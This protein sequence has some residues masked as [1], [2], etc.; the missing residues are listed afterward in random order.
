METSSEEG[1]QATSKIV[2]TLILPVFFFACRKPIHE[3]KPVATV[4]I[5]QKIID[6]TK[7][8]ST[9]PQK[10]KKKKFSLQ[11]YKKYNN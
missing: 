4:K 1:E 8:K 5:Q 2:F 3:M 11:V 9:A 6:T 10:K 7:K